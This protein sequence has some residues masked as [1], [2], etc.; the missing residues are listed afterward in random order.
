M[1]GVEHLLE[2]YDRLDRVSRERALKDEESRRLEA[3]MR[4]LGMLSTGRGYT[5][6]RAAA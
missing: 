2:E 1:T 3:V 6:R 5:P 4:R